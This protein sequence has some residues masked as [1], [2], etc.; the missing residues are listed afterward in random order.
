MAACRP[1]LKTL[2]GVE[3]FLSRFADGEWHGLVRPW[4]EAGRGRLE[5]A[6]VVAPTRGQTHAL[7]QRCV[8][9]GVSL[10]GVEFLTPSLAR[11]KRA[12]ASGIGRSLQLLVLRSRIEARL[13]PLDPA[14]PARRIW[15]S[16]ASDLESALGDF[17]DLIRGG[18]R[19]ADFPHAELR[20]VFGETAAWIER[21]GYVLGPLQDEEAGLAPAPAGSVRVA[22]RLLILAGGAEG[23]GDFFGLAA[24]ARRS[25]SVT[26][27]LAEP[28]F[29]GRGSGEEWVEVWQ[30]LLGAEAR[31]VDAQ[32]PTEN[33]APVAELW[34]G[35]AGSAERAEVIVGCSRSDEMEHVAGAVA[36]LLGE[37]ADNIAVIFPG[38]GAAHERIARLL[39]E[40]GVPFAD[41]IGTAGTPPADTRIQRAMA[42]FYER[43]CRLEEL[44][45]IW[46]LLRSLNLARISPAQ[47]RAACEELFD[48]VQSH[49]VE[50]HAGRLERSKDPSWREVGRVA[51]LLLPGWPGMLTPAEA[52]AR[53]EAARDRLML[54]EPAGWPALREFARRASEAM[55]ARALL[56]AIRAFLPEKGPVSGTAGRGGFARVTLTTC[57]RAAGV[58]W[59]DAIFVEA[60]AGI[61]PARRESS[62]WL[63]D[64]ARRELNE[65]GRFSLGLATSDDRAALDRRLYC[66]I[67][68]DT[69]CRVVMSAAVFSEEEPEVKLGPNAWL[70]RVMWSKGL[71]SADGAGIEA[72]ERLAAAAPPAAG[73]AEARRAP[74]D[75]W[76]G[77]W[78]GR[79]DPGR[80]FDEFFLA[81]TSGK[82]RPPRLSA[83][84]IERGI[85][86]PARLWFDAVLRV[87]RVEWR[88]FTRDRRRSIGDAVHRALAAALRGAPAEG[89][90]FR[91]PDRAE[92][93]ASLAAVLADM[94]ARWPGDQYWDSFHMDVCRA[95]RELL[96]RVFE[97]P[98]APFAAAEARL[99]EGAT[100]LAGEAGRIPVHGRMDLV[101]SDRPGWDGARIEIVDYK[102]GG[103]ARLT[104]RRMASSGA[105]L[106]LG[107]YLEAARSAGAAGSVWMLKPEERPM[108]IGMEELDRACAKLSVLGAH[109]TTGIYGARTPDRDEYT[110]G[111][112]WP[113]ACAPIGAAILESK[114]ART[115]GTAAGR[116]SAAN[117]DD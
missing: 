95:A 84:Q 72:F 24:L 116:E 39:E 104:A 22:D 60:N 38:A 73:A 46:P 30:A 48:E 32:E 15:M 79:R 82:S 45:A 90:F 105:S 80:P 19:P 49:S 2:P 71:L 69:R 63:G 55:P 59:S 31:L 5:R 97:L 93:A 100:V 3:L 16:L 112:E 13:A 8:A 86:D 43:G 18:F 42:D 68:R 57:R 113:L 117:D 76:I 67:A 62:C 74:P 106:Q 27:V 66:A 17:E 77:I 107:V 50:P 47:A 12:Q 94:R 99:P 14:D 53:F 20:E 75:G 102:T 37:G 34:T 7:K 83:S 51:R 110:R 56:G 92:A 70:E 21:N 6:I 11:K 28:E 108:K 89:D 9:E 4:L 114:F 58:A 103:E 61:W 35:D 1:K 96:D 88:P 29:R 91:L 78:S 52:L 41:L 54:A 115:F 64:D 65:R 10:L 36:R 87:A 98:A 33:C 44:L 85:G 109:L 23:W 111:F 40:R 101:L 25:T 26:V 81:D